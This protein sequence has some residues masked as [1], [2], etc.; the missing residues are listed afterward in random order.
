MSKK[1]TRFIDDS[2]GESVSYRKSKKRKFR[3]RNRDFKK[4]VE[5]QRT[6]TIK[7]GR[8]LKYGN[9]RESTVFP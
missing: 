7:R 6:L 4:D 5:K 3:E 9:G 1:I 2:V 8:N